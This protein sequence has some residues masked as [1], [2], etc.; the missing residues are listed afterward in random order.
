MP[1]P[2]SVHMHTIHQRS[3]QKVAYV[4]VLFIEDSVLFV[5]VCPVVPLRTSSL[6]DKNVC[7]PTLPYV[8]PLYKNFVLEISQPQNIRNSN[9]T[10][11]SIVLQGSC[12]TLSLGNILISFVLLGLTSFVQYKVIQVGILTSYSK[13]I[14]K[15]PGVS[16][17]MIPTLYQ[18]YQT[19]R[20]LNSPK[21]SQAHGY[22]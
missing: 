8:Y 7:L 2:R 14:Y 12:S 15:S 21:R 17:S 6:K 11:T 22:L 3:I 19:Q 5:S 1:D 9:I 13:S 4:H 20:P 10:L 16:L 18:P